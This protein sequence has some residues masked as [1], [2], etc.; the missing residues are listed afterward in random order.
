MKF[1]LYTLEQIVKRALLG[2]WILRVPGKPGGQ[3][4]EVHLAVMNWLRRRRFGAK[5][6]VCET[7]GYVFPRDDLVRIRM[8]NGSMETQCVE[9]IQFRSLVRALFLHQSEAA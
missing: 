1:L 5:T 8:S 2:S 6:A 7:C 9:C 4:A 3:L